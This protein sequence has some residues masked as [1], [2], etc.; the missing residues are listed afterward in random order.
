MKVLPNIPTSCKGCGQCCDIPN[1]LTGEDKCEHLTKDKLCA[2]YDTRPDICK[3]FEKGC[4]NC[5]T[6][7]YMN[8]F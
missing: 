8:R 5:I 1:V 7:L 2:I 3:N 4:K 6:A